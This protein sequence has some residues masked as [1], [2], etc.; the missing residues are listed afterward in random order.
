MVFS[1]YCYFSD[2]SVLMEDLESLVERNPRLAQL[3]D[4]NV[5]KVQ[6]AP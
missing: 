3:E 4:I 2:A 5:P 1:T 6:N